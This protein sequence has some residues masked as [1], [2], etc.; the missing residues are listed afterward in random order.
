MPW[1][2][3]KSNQVKELI[4]KLNPIIRGWAN[5]HRKGVAR[6]TFESLD[7]WMHKRALKIRQKKTSKQK[8]NLEKTKIFR[9]IQPGQEG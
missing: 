9:K 4:A 5:Y 2:K 1:L 8:R 3:Y 7:Q 6:K